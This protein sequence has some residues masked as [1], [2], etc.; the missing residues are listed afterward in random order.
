MQ[1]G[2]VANGA[3][4]VGFE[5]GFRQMTTTPSIAILDLIRCERQ[6]YVN[7]LFTDITPSN[8]VDRV[9][10]EPGSSGSKG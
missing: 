10:F 3:L 7:N 6:M 4:L 5:W 8:A 2:I 9:G 1:E